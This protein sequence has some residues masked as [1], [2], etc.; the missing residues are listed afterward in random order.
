MEIQCIDD[1]IH[2]EY[3]QIIDKKHKI[4]NGGKNN[5]AQQ[6]RNSYR[7][8]LVWRC[9]DDRKSNKEKRSEGVL[10]EGI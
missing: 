7:H 10:K 6:Q 9:W 1:K 5:K 2:M 3:N 8:R 4:A